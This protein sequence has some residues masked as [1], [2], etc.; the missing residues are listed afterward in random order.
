MKRIC[1]ATFCHRDA[2]EVAR[3]LLGKV[4]RHRWEGQWLAAQI[5]ETEAYYL[6]EKGSHASLGWTAKR[7]A[8]FREPGTI[9]MYYAHGGDSFNLSCA[10]EGNAVLIK[11]GVVFPPHSDSADWL[12]MVNTMQRLNP[13]RAKTRP[14]ERLCSGQTLFCRSLHLK[15]PNWDQQTFLDGVLEL[16]ETEY[17]PLTIYQT[18]RLGIPLGRDEQLLYR[19]I[20]A[21][22]AKQCTKNPLSHRKN[23]PTVVALNPPF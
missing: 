23:K 18:T 1:A 5:I 12:Q 4:I 15:V 21:S 2:S 7:D 3:D 10:G 8:L 11:S 6:A 17:R 16:N 22:Y 19:F 20:D 9:Y 14:V 13:L